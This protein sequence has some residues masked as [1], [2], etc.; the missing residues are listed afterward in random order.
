MP[1]REGDAMDQWFVSTACRRADDVGYGVVWAAESFS[2]EAEAKRYAAD[3]L[4]NGQ[5]IEAGLVR[6]D[7]FK[8]RIRW[9]TAPD[10]VA[11]PDR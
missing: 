2:G 1:R 6:G 10:W 7:N 5:R 3:A 4:A 9:R 11:A 8:V